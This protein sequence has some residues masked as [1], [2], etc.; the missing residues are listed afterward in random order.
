MTGEPVR[1]RRSAEVILAHPRFAEARG[2]HADAIVAIF[3]GDQFLTRLLGDSSRIMLSS[4][5]AGFHAAYDENDRSTWANLGRIQTLVGAWGVAS[6]RT[7]N[8]VVARFCQT[9]YVTPEPSLQDRRVRILRPTERLLAHDRA[10][11]GAFYRFLDVLYPGEGFAWFK[12]PDRAVHLALRRVAFHAL[13]TAAGFIPRH[14]DVMS[15]VNQDAGFVCLM[16]AVQA[17]CAETPG[18]PLTYQGVATRLGV[19]RT[20]VRNVFT[21]AEALGWV[22]LGGRGGTIRVLPRLWTAFDPFVADIMS[23]HAA[24]AEMAFAASAGSVARSA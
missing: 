16:M 19:S 1:P 13:G 22:E 17:A 18:P 14:P 21:R 3:D 5:L 9:G 24:V 11:L 8:D 10:Y 20:H 7:L 15:F 12:G 2:V 6:P 23:G 4:L